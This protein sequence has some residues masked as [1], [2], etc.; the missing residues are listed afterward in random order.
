[1]IQPR[2]FQLEDVGQLYRYSDLGSK[3]EGIGQPFRRAS[4]HSNFKDNWSELCSNFEG[5]GQP[6]TQSWFARSLQS[7]R[8]SNSKGVGQPCTSLHGLEWKAASRRLCSNFKRHWTAL[9]TRVDR[10]CVRALR[11][12][13]QKALDSLV[14]PSCPGCGRTTSTP[15]QSKRHWTALYTAPLQIFSFQRLTDQLASGLLLSDLQ[16]PTSKVL[17][18]LYSA[19]ALSSSPDRSSDSRFMQAL[20]S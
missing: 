19:A 17:D 20:S 15:F 10:D 14:H 18:N 1:V 3:F 11:V 6:C 4:V 16:V 8:R 9:Y 13:I 5:V 2:W 7:K 12:P